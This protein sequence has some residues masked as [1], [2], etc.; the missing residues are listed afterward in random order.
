MQLYVQDKSVKNDTSMYTLFAS[1]LEDN[2]PDLIKLDLG[3]DYPNEKS[4]TELKRIYKT[5]TN[6]WVTLD[7]MVECREAG[8]KQPVFFVVDS[9]LT[10]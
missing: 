5:M 8:G 2:C 4:L 7:L 9:A 10:I 6:P 1:T 3:R